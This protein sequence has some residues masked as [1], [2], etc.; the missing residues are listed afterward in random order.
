[1]IARSIHPTPPPQDDAPS[2]SAAVEEGVERP[3]PRLRELTNDPAR[4]YTARAGETEPLPD[5][6]AALILCRKGWAKVERHQITV[7]LDGNELQFT[8]RDSLVIASKNGTGER[9]L[10]AIN[11]RAPD[12]LHILTDDGRYIESIPRKGEAQWFDAGETSSAAIGTARAH[13][14]RD[15][16]RYAELHA[17]SR[18][19]AAADAA[20]NAAE[21]HRLVQTFP[22]DR[23]P[24][25]ERTSGPFPKA[26]EITRAIDNVERQR[27]QDEAARTR[28]RKITGGLGA[29]R[30]DQP[31]I[32]EPAERPAT[33]EVD[34]RP[35]K[36][37]I[38]RL[39]R[40]IFSDDKDIEPRTR[41]LATYALTGFANFAS[42]GIQIGGKLFLSLFTIFAT[43]LLLIFLYK[44]RHESFFLRLA[45][46]FILG[47]AVGNLI[48]RIFYGK[49]YGYAPYFYGKVVDFRL[50]K[51]GKAVDVNN[52]KEEIMN[53]AVSATSMNSPQIITIQIPVNTLKPKESAS[54]H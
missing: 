28:R 20:H 45:L 37:M 17:P 30:K 40:A 25:Q 7:T 48:D 39:R 54:G 36:E 34:P 26:E 8:S 49:I 23:G 42:I 19:A 15:M 29:F 1:M 24:E 44:N 50:P 12:V 13:L 3:L 51:D 41:I 38:G 27:S 10:L 35:E 52:I 22:L 14:Q 18:D 47:G 11:R 43:I 53:Q 32:A 33:P 5:S 6:V 9:V 31:L 4:E 21:V 46:A 2:V 16:A